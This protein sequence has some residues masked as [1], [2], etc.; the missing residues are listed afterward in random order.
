MRSKESNFGNMA[1]DAVRL[2][3]N[4][5]IA[6]INGG[7]LRSDT[8][9][10]PGILTRR[11]VQE[12]FPF[13]NLVMSISLTGAEVIAAIENGVSQAEN[14]AGRFPH[15][16]GIR[17]VA[18]LS[19]APGSRLVEITLSNGDAI[20]PSASYSVATYDYLAGG[21]DG[22]EMMVNAPRIINEAGA[23]LVTEIVTNY[24]KANSPVA[25]QFDNRIVIK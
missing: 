18:D 7:N 22:Y 15:V 4:T 21:G 19:K 14:N 12:T 6:I 24:I 13:N 3:L 16:S 17:F 11:S 1:A 23:S 10:E 9:Y 2:A 5:D 25:P 8:V 20:D